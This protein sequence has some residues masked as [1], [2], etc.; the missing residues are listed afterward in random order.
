MRAQVVLLDGDRILMARHERDG[1]V[2]WVL[3]GGAIEPGETSEQ[4]AIRELR[5]EC[6]LD[7]D[8]GGLLFVEPPHDIGGRRTS[9]RYTYLGR[10]VGGE[11]HQVVEDQGCLRGVAWMP[12]ESPEYDAATRRTLAMVQESRGTA[13]RI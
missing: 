9:P 13:E 7:I 1:H 12:F 8:L 4:A 5:E 3:P 10:I 11:V 2:H 6:G